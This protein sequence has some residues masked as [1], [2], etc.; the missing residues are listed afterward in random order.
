[1]ILFIK[2]FVYQSAE[3]YSKNEKYKEIFF[4]ED[5]L[6]WLKEQIIESGPSAFDPTEIIQLFCEDF[7]REIVI[8]IIEENE[9]QKEEIRPLINP[10]FKEKIIMIGKKIEGNIQ[11]I[12]LAYN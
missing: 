9:I 4:N 12:A 2:S 5:R 6:R 1:M 10:G 7:R 3:K 11:L 8:F